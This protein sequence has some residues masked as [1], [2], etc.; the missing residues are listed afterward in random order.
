MEH[1]AAGTVLDRS[2]AAPQF[3]LSASS[4]ALLVLMGVGL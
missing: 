1:D 3:F 2:R 4:A